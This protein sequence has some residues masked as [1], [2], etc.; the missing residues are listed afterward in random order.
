MLKRGDLGK[1]VL[2]F[3]LGGGFNSDVVLDFV[4]LFVVC[5]GG[6][7]VLL[8]SYGVEFMLKLIWFDLNVW[9]LINSFEKE[10]FV[11]VVIILFVIF[12]LFLSCML[13]GVLIVWFFKF[14]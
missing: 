10:E 6:V 13:L 8:F 14:D 4:D 7:G 3:N 5:V 12:I 9:L 1:V 2:D 11:M